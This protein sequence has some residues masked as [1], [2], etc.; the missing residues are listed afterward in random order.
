MSQESIQPQ[1][2]DDDSALD[3]AIEALGT[4]EIE[5]PLYSNI[6]SIASGA[7]S[8]AIRADRVDPRLESINLDLMR[9]GTSFMEIAGPR[10]KIFFNPTNTRAA[11]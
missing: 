10:R 9:H 11:I 5:S 7:V 4:A 2:P 8:S 3:F 1:K 6:E